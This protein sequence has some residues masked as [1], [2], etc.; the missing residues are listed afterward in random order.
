MFVLF[1]VQLIPQRSMKTTELKIIKRMNKLRS[2][3]HIIFH[4]SDVFAMLP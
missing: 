4:M 3:Q 1:L 2:M